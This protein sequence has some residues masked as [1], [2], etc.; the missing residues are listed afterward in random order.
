MKNKKSQKGIT[1]IAL[2]LTIIILLILGSV[3]TYTGI[4]SYNRAEQIKFVSQ[5]QLIQAKVDEKV[6]ED[7]FESTTIGTELTENE[8]KIVYSAVNTDGISLPTTEDFNKYVR[9]LSKENLRTQLELDN[10]DED[11]II[12]FK[13]RE[14]I[15]TIGFEYGGTTYY[16]QY[17]LPKGEKLTQYKKANTKLSFEFSK[18]AQD[19]ASIIKIVKVERTEQNEDGSEGEK[20]QLKSDT[21]KYEIWKKENDNYVYFKQ[22]NPNETLISVAGEYKI[23]VIDNIGNEYE[24][25]PFVIRITNPPRIEKNWSKIVQIKGINTSGQQIDAL[26]E[27]DSNTI[28]YDYSSN[29][30]FAYSKNSDN[31]YLVWIP[32]YAKNNSTNEIKFI[33]GNSNIFEDDTKMNDDWTVPEEFSPNEIKLTGFWLKVAEPNSENKNI[34]EF[35][36]NINKEDIVYVYE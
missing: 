5:M 19:L 35:L 11:I 30:K 21:L 25:D 36:K 1:I 29:I 9:Y 8:K 4:E 7:G 6:Q 31:D 16:T 17:K 2:V 33:K 23:K 13:T 24:G 22:L 32:R 14:V 20:V 34:D 3:A 27:L 18:V 12:N 28:W 26:I 15:S 10:I